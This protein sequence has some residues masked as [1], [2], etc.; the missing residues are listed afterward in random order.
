MTAALCVLSM[1]HMSPKEALVG[2]RSSSCELVAVE[3]TFAN[4]GHVLLLAAS[5]GVNGS[6][7]S[8]A[9]TAS[10]PPPPPLLL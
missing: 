8:A 4:N 2:G 6:A 3:S 10:R 7:S 5:E 1:Q 9:A